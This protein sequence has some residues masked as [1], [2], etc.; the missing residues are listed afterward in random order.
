MRH[1]C[2]VPP[3][4]GAATPLTQALP[5]SR[6]GPLPPPV[7]PEDVPPGCLLESVCWDQQQIV[8][9]HPAYHPQASEQLPLPRLKVQRRFN[10]PYNT[11]GAFSDVWVSYARLHI[12][13]QH[14]GMANHR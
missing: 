12:R 14:A 4:A 7:P 11:L 2:N 3:Q 9:M 6:L 13:S 8:L 1:N 5:A 10:M